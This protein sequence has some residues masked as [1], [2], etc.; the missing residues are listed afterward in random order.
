MSHAIDYTDSTGE[1]DTTNFSSA[2]KVDRRG[3]AD[4]GE[5]EFRAYFWSYDHLPSQTVSKMKG[6]GTLSIPWTL[7]PDPFVTASATNAANYSSRFIVSSGAI[8]V[9]HNATLDELYDYCKY[10]KTTT[11]MIEQPTAA[12]QIAT[13]DGKILDIGSMNI[14][15]SSLGTLRSGSKF[16]FLR[17]TGTATG[18]IESGLQD[19]TGI[20]AVLT[21]EHSDTAI[22]YTITE[23]D[24]KITSGYT[25]G[26][27]LDKFRLS[28]P[29]G[30]T[31][32]V[33][34]KAPRRKFKNFAVPSTDPTYI[35]TLERE[36]DVDDATITSYKKDPDASINN[37]MY[38]E[39]NTE[40]TAI[41]YGKINLSNK[42]QASKRLVDD[43]FQTEDG[44]RFLYNF[45]G[46]RLEEQYLAV[47][48]NGGAIK[49][50]DSSGDVDND[51]SFGSL[52]NNIHDFTQHDGVIYGLRKNALKV[53]AWNQEDGTR[54]AENDFDLDP[55]NA[56]PQG[57]SYDEGYL[58]VPDSGTLT[59][60]AYTCLLYTSPSPRDRQKSRMPS[61]A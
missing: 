3:L 16:N 43:R 17:T 52:V 61:S 47:C 30:S 49:A 60:F 13:A 27:G 5:D 51:R 28:L 26:S 48:F 9:T 38:I 31:L 50:Y 58:Y 55:A 57:I 25:Q 40:V 4:D 39:Y 56:D 33:C 1:W 18:S 42:L 54:I 32:R 19:S 2:F 15:V 36:Q 24:G 8:T 53:F 21:P 35:I 44:L 29:V 7:F 22:Y 41:R 20:T 34:A 23:S 6:R 46:S 10:L 11:G 45:P 12:D 59:V 14:G 37:N